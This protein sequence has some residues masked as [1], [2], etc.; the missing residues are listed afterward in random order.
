MKRRQQEIYKACNALW[1]LNPKKI[2][3]MGEITDWLAQHRYAKGNPN[4][5]LDYRKEW[6][7]EY[8]IE[9][10]HETPHTVMA[11]AEDA[12]IKSVSEIYIAKFREKSEEEIAKIKAEY[13]PQIQ[14]LRE[15][16]QEKTT[17][18]HDLQNQLTETTQTLADIQKACQLTTE[19]L[20]QTKKENHTLK[21]VLES[22]QKEAH[23][24]RD[25]VFSAHH[26]LKQ[27]IKEAL[28]Q[29][30]LHQSTITESYAQE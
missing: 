9:V 6:M 30:A 26:D 24:W 8:H 3:T 25:Q 2:P 4:Q 27:A 14:A 22:T 7:K 11:S 21:A 29:Q 18:C 5:T 17:Q 10:D 28:E 15:Q 13:E 19:L 12:L 16:L 1:A 20:D 23:V